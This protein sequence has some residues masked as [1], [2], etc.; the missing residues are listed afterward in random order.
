[1]RRSFA[2]GWNKQ[3]VHL[4]G[5]GCEGNDRVLGQPAADDKGDE[6]TAAPKLLAMLDA[7]GAAVS[8][9]AMGCQREI[10]AQVVRQG[11][12]YLLALKASGPGGCPRADN[13]PTPHAK[14]RRTM[15][16]VALDR[17]K[18]IAGAFDYHEHG[19][20]GHGRVERRRVR[21]TGD[22][23]CLGPAVPD[24]WAGLGSLV[25]AERTRQDLGD[26]QGRVTTERRCYLSSLR[27]CSAERAGR[28]A[29]GHWS[30]ENRLH[31]RLGVC[32]GEDDSRIR[33]DHAARNMS[34]PRRIV[35][36]K[37]KTDRSQKRTSLKTKRYRCSL[38]RQYL[39][40]MLQQ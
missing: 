22:V 35:L 29:R 2:H 16:D 26:A 6:I 36:N 5:A 11:A 1:M 39:I 34:R 9:D 33:K 38:D 28:L 13:Q 20:S 17:A 19:E 30:V 4:V 8:I 21:V 18:G 24:E 25:M 10:A 23:A 14:V 3:M 15:G 40:D 31:W 37:L 12:D 7:R 32:S 27:G